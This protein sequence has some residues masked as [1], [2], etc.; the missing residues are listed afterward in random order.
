MS[1]LATNLSVVQHHGAVLGSLLLR[2]FYPGF[3]IFCFAVASRLY[4]ILPYVLSLRLH[5]YPFNSF[6]TGLHQL[7]EAAGIHEWWDY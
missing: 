5:V 1:L 3:C 2:E 4:S 7:S 6:E